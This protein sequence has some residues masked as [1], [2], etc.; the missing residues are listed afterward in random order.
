M[1]TEG[2]NNLERMNA[3]EAPKASV[4]PEQSADIKET[5][6]STAADITPGLEA[7]EFAEQI[8]GVTEGANEKVSEKIS[9][10]ASEKKG[11]G[12]AAKKQTGK[13]GKTIAEIK[14]ELL[15]SLPKEETM[16]GQIETELKR[17][18]RW[19]KMRST[20]ISL[21]IKKGSAFELNNIAKKLREL[22]GILSMLAH[23][24]METLK[25]LW[26]RFVHG[27]I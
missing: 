6:S 10:R 20:M 21:G 19:L 27:L 2:K 7:M 14:S 24:A 15:Q 25:S 11:F 22:S 16:R 8:E 12:F 17:E 18:M 1:T 4:K 26:L 13:K 9:E 23:A 3:V 5:L